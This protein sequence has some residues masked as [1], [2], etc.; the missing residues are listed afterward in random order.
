MKLLKWF[1]LSVIAVAFVF[2]SCNKKEEEK[3][4][5]LDDVVGSYTG[6][7]TT[8]INKKIETIDLKEMTIEKS[9]E[10]AKVAL[11]FDY[12]N[13]AQS[14]VFNLP[15]VEN[16]K[17]KILFKASESKGEVNAS[18]EAAKKEFKLSWKLEDAEL[19]LEAKK[20]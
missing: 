12:N 18:Y 13:A 15:V 5:S 2:A 10:N 16:K 19:K 1:V 11:K 20:K 7:I 6:K 4:V 8:P 9:G 3:S 14:L 17:G